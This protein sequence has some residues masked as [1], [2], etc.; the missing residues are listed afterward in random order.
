MIITE[1]YIIR[2]DGVELVRTYSTENL[3]IRQLPTDIIYDEAI[4]VLPL[5]YTYEETDMPIEEY[6]LDENSLED[7]EFIGIQ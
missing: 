3:K 1:A 4:D 2:E 7:G 5:R 6:L